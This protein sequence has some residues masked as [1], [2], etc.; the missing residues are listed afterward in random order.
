MSEKNNA[1]DALVASKPAGNTSVVPLASGNIQQVGQTFQSAAPA[2]TP[3][4]KELLELQ[5][6]KARL[7]TEFAE[8]QLQDMRDR[9][10]ERKLKKEQFSSRSVENG[11]T[12]AQTQ[13]VEEGVQARCNHRKGGNGL[14]GYINGQG[15]DPNYAV[16]KHTMMNGDIHVR[17]MRCGKTWKPVLRTWFETDETYIKAY[18]E[19]EAAKNFPTNNSPSGSVIFQ[20]SDKGQS[21]REL[22]R[23]V[24]LR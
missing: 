8:A 18:T 13:A 20:F 11:K 19:Y 21:F 9:L 7:E 15:N 4:Q 3:E 22:N 24:S 12:L 10:D 5:L 17:C 2:L 6:R 14:G 1:V 23:Y 16:L